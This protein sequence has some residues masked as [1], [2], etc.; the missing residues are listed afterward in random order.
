M[1]IIV[2]TLPALPLSLPLFLPLLIQFI[3]KSL[4]CLYVING[5]TL[6][7]MIQW[8]VEVLQTCDNHQVVHFFALHALVHAVQ[9]YIVD[10]AA[11]GD[12]VISSQKVLIQ[13]P[14]I[15]F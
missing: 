7:E 14:K 3:N 12:V 4:L 6:D 5:R 15:N 13:R 10:N 2:I 9:G 11:V 1:A 8:V